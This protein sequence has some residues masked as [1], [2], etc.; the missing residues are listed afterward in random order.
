MCPELAD[1]PAKAIHDVAKL[2]KALKETGADYT[3]YIVDYKE[4]RERALSAF[5][6]L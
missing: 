5:K 4:S 1:V 3:T 6:A 2:P